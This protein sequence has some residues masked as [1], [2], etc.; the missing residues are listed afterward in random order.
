MKADTIL[1]SSHLI[2]SGWK[3]AEEQGKQLHL[4]Q[5]FGQGWGVGGEQHHK[6]QEA[7]PST[8]HKHNGGS[9][10]GLAALNKQKGTL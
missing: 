4:P 9:S 10:V 7:F 8:R 1:I 3:R 6:N 5:R 2:R